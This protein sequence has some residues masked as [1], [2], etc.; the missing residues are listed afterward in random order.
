MLL[1]FVGFRLGIGKFLIERLGFLDIYPNSHNPGVLIAGGFCF[2]K[3]TFGIFTFGKTADTDFV[4]WDFV[5]EINRLVEYFFG[6]ESFPLGFAEKFGRMKLY[7]Q[8]LTGQR[9][10]LR[11]NRLGG[12]SWLVFDCNTF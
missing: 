2:L 12:F 3:I 9:I 11:L 5:I 10:N 6:N 1:P 7:A 4:I 8:G